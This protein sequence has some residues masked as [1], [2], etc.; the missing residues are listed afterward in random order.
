[1]GELVV[2][3]LGHDVVPEETCLARTGVG[4]Q[5]FILGQFQCEFF[6]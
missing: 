6:T 3:V 5:R 1:M 4:D 2:R